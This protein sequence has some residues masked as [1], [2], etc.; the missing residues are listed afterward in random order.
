MTSP[1]CNQCS[2]LADYKIGT[3]GSTRPAAYYCEA[4]LPDW[5]RREYEAQQRERR[6]AEAR[7][8]ELE[9]ETA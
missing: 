1:R 7:L 2:A 3:E 6:E 9:R 5:L 8:A 4:H